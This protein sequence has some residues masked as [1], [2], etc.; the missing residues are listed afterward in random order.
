MI[1]LVLHFH[2]EAILGRPVYM[3]WMYPFERYLKKFKDYVRNT[4]KLEGSISKGYVVDE[5]VIFCSRYFDDVETRFNRPDMN[6]D[7]IHPT[8]QLSMFES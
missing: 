6:N 7:D 1:H 5:V 4:A 2:A 8:K 3:R